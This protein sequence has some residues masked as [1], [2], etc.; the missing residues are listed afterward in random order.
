[1]NEKKIFQQR[2]L[3]E[4]IIGCGILILIMSFIL[5]K[6]NA[7]TFFG[8]AFLI[9]GILTFQKARKDEAELKNRK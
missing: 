5:N 2:I 9:I 8:F 1:M 7:A 4:V 3:S 6:M